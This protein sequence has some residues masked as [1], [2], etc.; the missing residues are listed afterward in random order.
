MSNLIPEE[1]ISVKEKVKC[2]C[3]STVLLKNLKSHEKTQKQ[4]TAI[5]T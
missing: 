1:D 3:G 2:S 4:N 5:F